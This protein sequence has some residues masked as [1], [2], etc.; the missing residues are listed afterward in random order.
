MA[1]QYA[2]GKIVTNG[3][4]LAL[5]A[6]DGNSYASGSTTW[7]DLSGNNNHATATGSVLPSY[8][9]TTGSVSNFYFNGS[10]N[11]VIPSNIINGVSN[12]ATEFSISTFFM[13]AVTSSYT[14]IFEKQ[15]SFGTSI[16]RL[17]WGG[18]VGGVVYFTNYNS[19]SLSN[20]DSVSTIAISLFPIPFKPNQWYQYTTTNTSANSGTQNI[21]VNGILI[22]SSTFLAAF[23]DNTQTIGIGGNS[24][25]LIGNISS[26]QIYNRAL[27]ASEVLQNYNAQKSRF[28][29]T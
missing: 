1:V 18:F 7:N 8:N 11:F 26:F 25:K 3:L 27:S 10:G 2:N 29:L 4:V 14:A 13:Y 17:D 24:R 15:T 20:S 22:K 9:N 12:F 21:Y 23:P 16:P 5:D 19:S 6:S 28:G